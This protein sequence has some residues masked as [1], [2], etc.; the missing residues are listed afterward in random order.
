MVELEEGA[1]RLK[2]S[3]YNQTNIKIKETDI[4]QMYYIDIDEVLF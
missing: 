3:K 2:L 1:E 4:A